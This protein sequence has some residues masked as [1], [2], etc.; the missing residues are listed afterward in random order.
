MQALAQ[1]LFGRISILGKFSVS[2]P[3]LYPVGYTRSL[4]KV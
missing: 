2:I 1:A 3:G 4:P